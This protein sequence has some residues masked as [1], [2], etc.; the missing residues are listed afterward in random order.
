M[1]VLIVCNN[2]YMRGNGICTA[3]TS[4]LSRLKN[5]GIEARLLACK[6]PETDGPQ[7]D[8]PL[9]HFKFPLFEPIIYANG[10]RY[11][12]ADRKIIRKA[13]D[14]ADIIHLSEGFPLEAITARIAKKANKPC[15]GTYHLFSNNITTN[16]GMRKAILLNKAITWYFRKSVYDHCKY[17]HC[18]S[19]TVADHLTESGFKA[20]MRIISNGIDI[21]EENNLSKP[22]TN[23]I[24]IIC[25][26][27]LANEKSQST[28][29]DAMRYS[30]YSNN[31]QLHF[32]GKGPRK[33]SYEKSA[34]KLLK[35]GILRYR[36]TFGFY[37]YTELRQLIKKAYLFVHCAW[38]EV[39]GL[40][41][42]EALMEGVV[43]I[44]AKS[45]LTASTQFA[46]DSRSIFNAFD[47]KML[48]EKIDW[49]IEHPEQ[50]EAMGK[51]Y[52]ESVKQYD[53][54]ISTAN[55]IKMYNE[56]LGL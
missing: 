6:N 4:L 50:R 3:V 54:K 17:I 1:N 53:S 13:V 32:A 38:V 49:W 39:E 10:F 46:L 28:L 24:G 42:V 47:S 43:P 35:D 20:Q 11:A 27:R 14:W 55:I 9:K 45:K 56:C 30:R 2:A 8:Y 44:I 25:I 29:L 21:I 36:P 12:K 26:G 19:K 5:A 33:K 41:C 18:P 7:P 51:M 52:A 15:V 37:N 40:S 22:S 34:E 48:A 23:P 16:L 31:I